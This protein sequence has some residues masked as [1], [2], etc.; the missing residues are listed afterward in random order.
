VEKERKT[1]RVSDLLESRYSRRKRT[2]EDRVTG[3]NAE[4]VRV[5][6]EASGIELF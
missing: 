1:R 5:W 4:S 6:A 2:Y 3:L